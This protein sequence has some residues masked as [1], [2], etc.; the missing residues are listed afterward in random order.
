MT[1]TFKSICGWAARCQHSDTG[2]LSRTDLMS[3]SLAELPEYAIE[4]IAW[5]LSHANEN[6]RSKLQREYKRRL[7]KMIWFVND[8]R[9]RPI[10]TLAQILPLIDQ[11]GGNVKCAKWSLEVAGRWL[12]PG[13]SSLLLRGSN[14]RVCLHPSPRTPSRP[15]LT[16]LIC[17]S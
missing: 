1:A 6:C 15:R 16:S 12:G 2:T 17:L 10:V 9:W 14:F 13:E 4:S 3:E 11:E 5:H 7:R 8:A